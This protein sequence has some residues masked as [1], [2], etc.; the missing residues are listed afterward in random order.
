MKISNDKTEVIGKTF[1]ISKIPVYLMYLLF[2]IP[3]RSDK[4]WKHAVGITICVIHLLG[5][6]VMIIRLYAITKFYQSIPQIPVYLMLVPTVGSLIFDYLFVYKSWIKYDSSEI[7]SLLDKSSMP[8]AWDAKHKI[9]VTCLT[10]NV[11]LLVTLR[12]WSLGEP[13][14]DSIKTLIFEFITENEITKDYLAFSTAIY[15]YYVNT[16]SHL[17]PVYISY[18]CICINIIIIKLH[19]LLD[20]LTENNNA[21][22][23]NETMEKFMRHLNIV[24]NLVSKVDDIYNVNI[25]CF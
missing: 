13:F 18:V 6:V 15:S 20:D 19:K 3:H 25:F 4:K 2:W 8:K 1:S 10:G 9:L 11:I 24:M 12:I 16:I 17:F 23:I 22:T 5:F 21:L 14:Y 7:L